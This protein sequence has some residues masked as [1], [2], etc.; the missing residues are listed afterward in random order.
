MSDLNEEES[1]GRRKFIRVK[2]DKKKVVEPEFTKRVEI[3][4]EKERISIKQSQ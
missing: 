3:D 1:T 2:V 4:I